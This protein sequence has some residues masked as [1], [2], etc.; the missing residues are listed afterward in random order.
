MLPL[1]KFAS[2]QEEHSLRNAI[3]HLADEFGLTEGERKELFPSGSQAIFDNRVSWA[4]TYLK[5]A[6][7]LDYTRRSYFKILK[8]E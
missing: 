2:D 7:L 4:K 6:G 5:K 8:K 3:N 1:L